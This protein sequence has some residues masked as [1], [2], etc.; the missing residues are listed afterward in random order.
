MEEIVGSPMASQVVPAPPPSAAQFQTLVASTHLRICVSAHPWRSPIWAAPVPPNSNPE[1]FE[2]APTPST[3]SISSIS[4]TSGEPAVRTIPS[5]PRDVA[6]SSPVMVASTISAEST[7]PA[8]VQVIVARDEAVRVV[9]P[10]R[11]RV[12]AP[13][14]IAPST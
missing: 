3:T 6:I 5:P 12:V 7:Q 10:E 8:A 1:L 9:V 2:V 14:A 13:R 4:R 11:V